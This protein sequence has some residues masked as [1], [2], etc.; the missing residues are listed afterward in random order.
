MNKK[1]IIIWVISGFVGGVIGNII[2]Y[3]IKTNC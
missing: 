1:E 3:I 2:L